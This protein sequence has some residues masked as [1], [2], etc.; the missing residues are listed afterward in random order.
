[1][2]YDSYTKQNGECQAWF[3]NFVRDKNGDTKASRI[4]AK[5]RHIN[6]GIE[7]KRVKTT[8]VENRGN[9]K[10]YTSYYKGESCRVITDGNGHV[11]YL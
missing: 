6:S 8:Q 2:F 3:G 5:E 4:G 11:Q 1:M 7:L 10:E 9:G